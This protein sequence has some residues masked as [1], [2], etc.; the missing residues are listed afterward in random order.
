MREWLSGA[1]KNFALAVRG[2]VRSPG[3]TIVAVI[4]LALGM[5]GSAAIYTMLDRV[6][7]DPLPYPDA[8]R[9]VELSNQVPGVGPD[10]VW[11][12]STA[13]FV[14]FTQHASSLEMVGLY[15]SEGAI[16]ETPNGPERTF[17]WGVT[18]SLFPMLG[19][20]ARLGRVITPEDDRP[21]GPNVVVLSHGFWQRLYGSD[22]S[23]IGKTLSVYGEPYEIIGVLEPDVRVPGSSPTQSADFWSP[24]QIDPNGEFHNNHVFPMMARLAP[25]ADIATAEAEL[26]RLTAQLPERFP[27][28]YSQRFFDQYGFR[29]QVIPLKESIVGEMSR[30]LWILFG[31]VGLVLLIAAANVANL[32]LVRLEARRRELAIRSALGASTAAIA[33]YVLTESLILSLTGGALGLLVAFFGVPALVSMAPEILPR[34]EALHMDGATVVFTVAVSLIVSLALAIY[35]LMRHTH[36]GDAALLAGAGGVGGG[37]SSTVGRDRQRLRA[38]LVVTQVALALTLLVGAGL[39]VESLQRLARIDPGIDAEGVVTAGLYL[40]PNKYRDDTEMWA[41]YRQILDG[42]RALPGVTAAGMSEEIPVEHGFGCTI[43]GFE[44]SAVYARIKDAGMTTCAGQEPTTPG[45]FESLHIPVIKGRSF[46][47]EDNDSPTRAAVVVS[48][49]FAERFWPGE[50]PIGKGVAPSGRTLGPFYHVIGVVGDVPA[51]SLDGEPAIAIYYP[52]VQNPNT[53]GHWWWSPTALELMVRTERADP[54]SIFPEIRRV[55]QSVDPS[56]PLANARTMDQIIA[57]STA[58]Y[59]F[60]SL[61]LSIAASVAVILAAVGLYGVVSYVIERRTREIGMRIAIGARPGEVE[62][63]FVARSL[64]LVATGLVAGVGLALATTRVMSGLLFG[65]APNDPVT[66]GSAAVLLAVVALLASWIPARRAARVDPVTAL[67][68]E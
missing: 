63:L 15:R 27:T 9:L 5:G 37:R 45:Y 3:F 44:D 64:A 58:R 47:D 28:A 49:A 39:L 18:A 62:R 67:R 56:I 20:R 34:S 2:L 23:V 33:R 61:L 54:L 68:A 38:T 24:L 43:Q 53:P 31:A 29:T 1:G 52:I 7:L 12:M 55:V 26:A 25:G 42:I 11:N 36:H 8:E 10:E 16:V 41:T 48:R 32:F 22:P 19:A 21:G 57:D 60:T 51:G 35:P 59:R 40:M 14:Y 6:V 13:Q 4:T 50:E 66:F 46:T 17:A 30:N 65:I